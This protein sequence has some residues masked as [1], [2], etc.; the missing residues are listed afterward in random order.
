M[1]NRGFICRK[2][3]KERGLQEGTDIEFYTDEDDQAD[4]AT[5]SKASSG[6]D[7][8]RESKVKGSDLDRAFDDEQ[9]MKKKEKDGSAKKKTATEVDGDAKAKSKEQ[10]YKDSKEK[11]KK[12]TSNCG[13]SSAARR[14]SRAEFEVDASPHR[15]EETHASA[16]TAHP[17]PTIASTA[18]T[19]A[20]GGNQLGV[21]S[22]FSLKEIVESV[23][24]GEGEVKASVVPLQAEEEVPSE[25]NCQVCGLE[26][27]LLLCDYPGCPKV[28]HRVSAFVH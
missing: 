9:K 19:A 7:T 3:C 14:R 28:Y 5:A 11:D 16:A 6:T 20:T 13:G 21:E 8:H 25:D 24:R 22:S 15:A 18:A 17:Q 12:R 4:K 10:D 2:C 26:G 23:R 1:E 27:E